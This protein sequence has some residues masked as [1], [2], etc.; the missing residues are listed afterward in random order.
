MRDFQT[1]TS[2][3]CRSWSSSQLRFC[4]ANVTTAPGMTASVESATLPEKCPCLASSPA[5]SDVGAG[6]ESCPIAV[7]KGRN[8]RKIRSSTALRMKDVLNGVSTAFRP[9]RPLNREHANSCRERAENPFHT[10]GIIAP[11]ERGDIRL[12]R[13]SGSLVLRRRWPRPDESPRL[14]CP[15]TDVPQKC[16][17]IIASFSLIISESPL[18]ILSSPRNSGNPHNSH[19]PRPQLGGKITTG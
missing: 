6:C 13:C 11:L 3:P 2:P 4:R 16:R 15:S 19:K 7:R 10:E 17:I 18:K 14:V 8:G 12:Q 1:E 5:S 9:Q